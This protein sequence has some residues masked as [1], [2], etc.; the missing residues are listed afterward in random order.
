[1]GRKSMCAP[2]HAEILA[3]RANNQPSRKIA[4]R[5]GVPP[6]V[7]ASYLQRRRLLSLMTPS[8]RT[9]TFPD[10]A[11]T[12]LMSSGLR[13]QEIA[14]RL[15]VSTSCIERRL[16]RLGL[17]SGRTGPKAGPDHPMWTG[18]RS[19]EK[20][21]YIRVYAPLHPYSRRSGAVAEHRLVM[22][23]ALGRY[24]QP[25]EVVDH[26]DGHPR[27]NW[28]SNLRVFASNA[29]H[30]RAELTA[31][32]KATPR[33]SIPGAYRSIEKIDHCPEEQETLAQCP[34]EIRAMLT[35]YIAAHRPT[36]EHRH[37]PR[38]KMRLVSPQW[39]FRSMSTE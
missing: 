33:R 21:G 23:V 20:H 25:G 3:M 6:S 9:R 36:T 8:E 19:L 34:S 14:D 4:D 31:R 2:H 24:L 10:A 15:G 18:G 35:E 26:I 11:V 39:E 29:D 1:M 5:I 32:E 12:D 37:L 17:S 7:L 27:H 28:P 16:S 13:V 22:E 30:L 38:R